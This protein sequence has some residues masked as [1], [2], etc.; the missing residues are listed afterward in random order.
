MRGRA[1]AGV[2]GHCADRAERFDRTLIVPEPLQRVERA[3]GHLQGV[4]HR[5][6]RVDLYS[7]LRP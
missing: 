1:V 5:R 2:E 4:R 3:L 7:Q 6:A